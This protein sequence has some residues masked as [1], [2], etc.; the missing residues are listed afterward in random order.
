MST[1]EK[2]NIHRLSCSKN[3]TFSWK[4]EIVIVQSM[5]K[6]VKT[7]NEFGLDAKKLF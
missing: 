1:T 5:G 3:W 4:F 2:L 7:A 6:N